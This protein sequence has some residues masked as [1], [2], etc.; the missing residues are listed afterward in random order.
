MGIPTSSYRT[1]IRLAAPPPTRWTGCLH[2]PW[3]LCWRARLQVCGMVRRGRHEDGHPS[4]PHRNPRHLT[5]GLSPSHRSHE[6]AGSEDYSFAI[7]APR[8]TPSPA[9]LPFIRSSL[10]HLKFSSIAEPALTCSLRRICST[11]VPLPSRHS[12][13]PPVK[14]VD[15]F[16]LLA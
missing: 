16:P 1:H 12:R 11:R 4:S 8:K 5:A 6:E 9:S 7:R 15:S 10:A 3:V 14:L 13:S 2:D